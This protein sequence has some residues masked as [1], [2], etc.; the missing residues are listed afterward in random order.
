MKIQELMDRTGVKRFGTAR[1][2][3]KDALVEM[4]LLAESHVR[5]A[6]INIEKD[7]RFYM[8]PKDVVKI[9]DVRCKNQLNTE[10]E[11]RSIP[12]AIGDVTSKD[13]DGK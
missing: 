2:W 1:A 4:N 11:Y 9:L 3:I 5:T 12:R 13:S 8:I 7:S 10:D 6:R